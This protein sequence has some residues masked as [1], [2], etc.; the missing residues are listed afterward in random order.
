MNAFGAVISQL[1][2]HSFDA[3]RIINPYTNV[4]LNDEFFTDLEIPFPD[5]DITQTK[6]FYE[7]SVESKKPVINLLHWQELVLII[8]SFPVKLMEQELLCELLVDV[9]NNVFLN[10]VN[11]N[12]Q[13]GLISELNS[14]RQKIITDELTGLYN[15]RFIEEK[16]PVEIL[17]SVQQMSPLSVVFSDLDYYKNIN[18]AF[19]HAAG[20][21]IL[22]EFAK[23][24]SKNIRKESDWIARYGGEEFIIFLS[25]AGKEKAIEIAERIRL[26]VMNH[27][28]TYNG[29]AIRLTC[30]FGV[31]TMDD[32]KQTPTVDNILDAVDKRLYQA[33]HHG[34]NIVI[35]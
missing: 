28:F 20:D 27:T 6:R 10:N 18:D 31:Y 24:L 5:F 29:R 21:Y 16:L 26:A 23:I 2:Q 15:R 11:L 13:S 1:Q 9:T 4:V 22:C 30:S 8:L 17:T 34:R 32:F 25:G 33:K 7:L 14:L 35:S 12:D 3:V 19:G